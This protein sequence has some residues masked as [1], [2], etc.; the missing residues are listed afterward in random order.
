MDGKVKSLL[1]HHSYTLNICS[2]SASP[3]ISH[4]MRCSDSGQF[5]CFY[6]QRINVIVVPSSQGCHLGSFLGCPQPINMIHDL[7]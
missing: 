1:S 2:Y 7:N 6:W 4:S 5:I 3:R